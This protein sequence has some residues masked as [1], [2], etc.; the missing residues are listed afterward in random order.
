MN[1]PLNILLADD[2]ESFKLLVKRSIQDQ[3]DLTQRCKLHCVTDGT[4]AVDFVLGRGAFTDRGQFPAPDLI[5]LDHRMRQMDG[6]EAMKEIKKHPKGRTT[7]VCLYS[8]STQQKI[9][10]L[11]YSNGGTFY[12]AKPL[13][14]E[15]LGIKMRTLVDFATNVLDLPR[16][17]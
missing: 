12:F 14:Y 16:A 9:Y 3:E 5:L 2:D 13:D 4:E 7:P 10:D 11:C 15:E 1:Q 17:G 6:A 8:T